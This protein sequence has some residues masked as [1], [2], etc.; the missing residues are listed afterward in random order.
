MLPVE[1]HEPPDERRRGMHLTRRGRIVVMLTIVVVIAAVLGFGAVA[2]GRALHTSSA[3][4]YTGPGTGRV[5]IQVKD[6]D[7]ASAIARTLATGGVVESS[8][9]FVNVASADN[10]AAQIQPGFYAMRSKMSAQDAFNL[11]LDPKAQI[12]SRVTIPEGT[13]VKAL[14]ALIAAHTKI[15]AADVQAAL[16]KPATLGLPSYAQGSVEGFLFP[17]TYDV[18]P[19]ETATQLLTAMTTRFATAAADVNLV[20]GAK[21]LGYTPRQVV[22]IASIIERESAG[23]AD[24]PKVARVFYNR[25]AQ[26]RP[27]GSEFTVNYSGG[28]KNNPYNT[29][30]HTGF[31]PGPYDS[32]GEATLKAALNPAAGNFIYFVTLPKEGTQFTASDSEFA[33]L[34]TQCQAEGGC[35]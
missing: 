12:T 23:P 21:A 10:R 7:S 1:L 19:G 32:P 17:A 2:V 9:A 13:S 18:S 8:G 11:L 3:K 31:P 35:K 27:L 33:S 14:E 28:D 16:A 26:N 20:A 5:V 22:I 6:G 25:L 24:A 29:Y 34:T 4:D 15:T 30:T